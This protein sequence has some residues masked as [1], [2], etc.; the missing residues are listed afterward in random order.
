[1]PPLCSSVCS[2]VNL[3][4]DTGRSLFG[5]VWPTAST[6]FVSP[7]RLR[8]HESTAENV[9]GRSGFL[10][11]GFK[12]VSCFRAFQYNMVINR[13]TLHTRYCSVGL[14]DINYA[15]LTARNLSM[16]VG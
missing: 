16:R 13:K 14:C 3:F 12:S 8:N 11:G 4:V 7:L 1:M 2:V 10:R 5:S 9:S 6:P 15:T